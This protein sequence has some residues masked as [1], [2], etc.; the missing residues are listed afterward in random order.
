MSVST[1]VKLNSQNANPK[2]ND[3]SKSRLNRYKNPKVTGPGIW[4]YGHLL[5]EMAAQNPHD[6][7]A[8]DRASA[9]IDDIRFFFSL[10][11][12]VIPI[13]IITAYLTILIDLRR[14]KIHKD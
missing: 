5:C 12:I 7:V 2:V 8:F 11:V 6:S 1:K 13:L 14:L 10:V 9:F 3:T 4:W